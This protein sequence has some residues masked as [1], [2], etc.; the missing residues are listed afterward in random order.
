MVV[1]DT[2][3]HSSVGAAGAAFPPASLILPKG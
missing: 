3:I 2:T 1:L